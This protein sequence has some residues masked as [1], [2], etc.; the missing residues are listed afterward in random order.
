MYTKNNLIK[1]TLKISLNEGILASV[2]NGFTQ[3]FFTPFLLVLGGSTFQVGLLNAFPYLFSSI[4]Q[5]KIPDLTA[6][7]K[8]RKKV[9]T[10]FAFMQSLSL[11]PIIYLAIKNSRLPM[12]YIVLVTIYISAGAL[13]VAPWSSVMSDLVNKDKW[14]AFFGWRNK[15][16]GFVMFFTSFSASFI[17]YLSKKTNVFYGFA[18]IFTIA[19]FTRLISSWLLGMMYE[20]PIDHSRTHHFSLQA[21]ISKYKESNF[22]K[23]VFLCALFKFAVGLSAPFFAV[24]MLRDYKFSYNI[25]IFLIVTE[26]LTGFLMIGRWGKIADS[27]GN[28]RIIKICARIVAMVPILWLFSTNLI[29]LFFA[30]I[31]SGAG[32]SGLNI[33]TSN[34]I[35]DS[36]TKE[37]RTRCISFYNF[38]DNSA[39]CA[40]TL[41]GGILAPKCPALFGYSLLSI[42]LISGI[43]RMAIG[44]IIPTKIK[45]VRHVEPINNAK[46]FIRILS[47]KPYKFLK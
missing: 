43:L 22:T 11:I 46:L 5:L 2:T 6:K 36:V 24:L 8:S 21:F 7:L 14:G 9:F 42:F 12:F 16:F 18:I 19:C 17:L 38:F 37:K 13:T 31:V 27:T 45:E 10:F 20:P 25:Y 33:A 30:Q 29:Y 34:F 3:N 23:F 15:I 44:I 40:G 41:I 35:Y 1:R 26:M 4:I 28:M 32:W 47:I 39:L